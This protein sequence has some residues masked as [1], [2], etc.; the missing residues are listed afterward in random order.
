MVLDPIPQSL[1][2]HFFGS[3]PQPPTSLRSATDGY[4]WHFQIDWS[5]NNTDYP[6]WVYVKVS[7]TGKVSLSFVHF[8]MPIPLGVTFS[9]AVSKLK[10]QSFNVTFATF[11]WK[12][13]FE[14]WA[15][16]FKRAFR[17]CH[18]RWDW[19]YLHGSCLFCIHISDESEPC[20]KQKHKT[21]EQNRFWFIFIRNS[22]YRKVF[23][24]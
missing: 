9:N 2:V 22:T 23:W 11:Q 19:L 16:S 7:K 20:T 4:W 14:F 8:R 24:F 1:P 15:L 5:E 10:A 18:R 3:R 6:T 12:E 21:R 13:T 17:K